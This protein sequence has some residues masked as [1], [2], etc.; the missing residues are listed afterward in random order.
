M[1]TLN[2]ENREGINSLAVI[3]FDLC[4]VAPQPNDLDWNANVG[5][6]LLYALCGVV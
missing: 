5:A 2:K 1:H 4:E 3:G 6:R